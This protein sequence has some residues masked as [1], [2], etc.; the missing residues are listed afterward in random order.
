[1]AKTYKQ[2][3]SVRKAGDILRYLADAREPASGAE[4]GRAVSL[5]MGTVMCHLSTLEA[6]GFVRRAGGSGAGGGDGRWEL[7]MGLALFWARA[8]SK[9]EA[10]RAR[11]GREIE[12]LEGLGA[13]G[14]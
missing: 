4:V 6:C 13:N 5:P 14:Q 11:I 9:L 7:G 1:M 2:I 10:D 8:K 12:T 3:S